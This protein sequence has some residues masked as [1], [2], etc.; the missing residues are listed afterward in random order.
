MKKPW[1]IIMAI[2]CLTVVMASGGILGQRLFRYVVI[3]DKLQEAVGK[4]AGYTETLLK[5]EN[6]SALMTYGELFELCDKSIDGR[7]NLLIEL[8]GLYPSINH[9]LKEELISYLNAEN[10]VSRAKRDF[11]RKQMQLSA[12]DMYKEAVEDIPTSDYGYD[13]YRS[14]TSRRKSE[15]E[16]AAL[17][18]QNSAKSFLESYGNVLALE[19][20]VARTARH[21]SVRFVPVFKQ[22]EQENK[23][24]AANA[25]QVASLYAK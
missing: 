18:V 23:T 7:T 14:I 8:R 4:D 6:D 12:F 16:D 22:Y 20:T 19:D 5:V 9:Q 11:Y 25:E 13:Y 24:A 3:K 15:V 1:K 10:E 2:V 21:S 17:Q